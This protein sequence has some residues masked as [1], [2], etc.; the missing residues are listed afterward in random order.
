MY[1]ENLRYTKEHEWIRVEGDRGT[2][3]VTDYAQ[4]QLGDVVF[5]ELPEAGRALKAGENFGTVESVKAVSELF[6]PVAGDV[7][8]SNA[9][10]VKAPESINS[11]P[12]GQGWMIVVKLKDPAEPAALM[13][14]KAYAALVEAE[15]K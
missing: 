12:Y 5:L 8:E 1:P 13:D 11:D 10:L 15:G 9:A 3:G 4:Q 14:A 7:V 2:I 6:C